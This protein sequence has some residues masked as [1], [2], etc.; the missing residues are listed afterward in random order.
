MFSEQ[1]REH[2]DV[3]RV[4]LMAQAKCLW[5]EVGRPLAPNGGKF[6]KGMCFKGIGKIWEREGCAVPGAG[7]LGAT[8]PPR[9]QGAGGGEHRLHPGKRELQVEAARGL[10]GDAVASLPSTPHL[11]RAPSGATGPGCESVSSGP[12]VGEGGCS[13]WVRG[14]PRTSPHP[15]AQSRLSR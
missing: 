6:S 10:G 8:S 3:I 7:D 14:G 15:P 9:L 11:P 12:E 2:A 1:L 13:G 4:W 5:Q